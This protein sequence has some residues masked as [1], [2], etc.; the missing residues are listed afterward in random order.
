MFRWPK[1][2][3][4]LLGV[5]NGSSAEDLPSSGDLGPDHPLDPALHPEL[6]PHSLATE[7]W[8][9]FLDPAEFAILRG[10]ATERAG[11]GRYLKD[12]GEGF[13]H[14][15]GC[16]AQ[17]YPSQHKFHSGCGWPSFFEEISPGAVLVREDRSHFMVR[18]E[19]LCA[20]CDGHLGHVFTDAPQTP[21]GLRHCINGF[22]LVF[23]PKGVEPAFAFRAHRSR[24]ASS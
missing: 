6:D 11:T 7:D 3:R 5:P 24:R 2:G 23:V 15:A 1:F 4:S 22:A 16:G 20:R 13:F 9:S 12:P 18:Q 14:C 17:L 8:Q 10:A 21:T 19:L